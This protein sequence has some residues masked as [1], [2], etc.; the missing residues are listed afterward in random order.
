MKDGSFVVG[1]STGEHGSRPRCLAIIVREIKQH[2]LRHHRERGRQ[3]CRPRLP[4]PIVS[5]LDVLGCGRRRRDSRP[6]SHAAARSCSHIRAQRPCV[7]V[8]NPEAA[9]ESP[10]NGRH[11]GHAVEGVRHAEPPFEQ[12]RAAPNSSDSSIEPRLQLYWQASLHRSSASRGRSRST[13]AK[14]LSDSD[15][16]LRRAMASRGAAFSLPPAL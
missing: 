14:T 9:A 11:I 7:G 15:A 4:V 1:K 13:S 3:P 8:E 16:S 5:E 6:G 2:Q 10:S 12:E